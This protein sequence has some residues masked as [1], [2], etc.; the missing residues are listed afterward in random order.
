MV[1]R[2]EYVFLRMLSAANIHQN[3]ECG[4]PTARKVRIFANSL[5]YWL[6]RL[7]FAMARVSKV[8]FI[9]HEMDF[10]HTP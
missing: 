8:E 1:S 6:Q 2:S 7:N 10:W 4:K 9:F 3:L 5:P